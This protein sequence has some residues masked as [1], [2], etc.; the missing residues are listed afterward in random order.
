[1]GYCTTAFDRFIFSIKLERGGG[2]EAEAEAGSS[3]V[4]LLL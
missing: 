4:P 1:M 3:S 2:A